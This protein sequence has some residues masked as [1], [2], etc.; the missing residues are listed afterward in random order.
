METAVGP[1]HHDARIFA[2]GGPCTSAGTSALGV[3]SP[4]GV[5]QH[6]WREG[7]VSRRNGLEIG[8]PFRGCEDVGSARA[9]RDLPKEQ[10]GLWRGRQFYMQITG[11]PSLSIW[12][13][14]IHFPDSDRH[15]GNYNFPGDTRGHSTSWGRMVD[16]CIL[17]L[18]FKTES[19][20]PSFS[21]PGVA[22]HPSPVSI[23]ESIWMG[24]GRMSMLIRRQQ[25]VAAEISLCF[26]LL[27]M[28]QA[29][30][31]GEYSRDIRGQPPLRRCVSLS[32]GIDQGARFKDVTGCIRRPTIYSPAHSPPPEPASKSRYGPHAPQLRGS[33]IVYDLS[34]QPV[35]VYTKI[36]TQLFPQ[37]NF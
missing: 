8:G 36:Q 13:R 27:V 28:G 20:Y 11:R 26:L 31:I 23:N 34:Y 14:S 18:G 3:S 16:L 21:S 1:S 29:L 24:R 32:S 33:G 4:L 22:I 9:V 17:L 12:R 6:T 15:C 35:E 30:G 2:P 25:L 37:M 5:A 19:N 7:R 10:S